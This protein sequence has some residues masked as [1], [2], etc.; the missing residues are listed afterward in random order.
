MPLKYK[1]ISP[2]SHKSF[3][4]FLNLSIN[5]SQVIKKLLY[6][7]GMDEMNFY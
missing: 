5:N 6:L 3:L 2:N 4:F 7:L 1:Q